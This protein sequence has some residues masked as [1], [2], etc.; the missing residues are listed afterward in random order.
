[1]RQLILKSRNYL[2]IF[3]LIAFSFFSCEDEFSQFPEVPVAFTINLA[4]NND[5]QFPGNSVYFAGVGY[6]GIIVTCYTEGVYY[7]FDAACP[8]EISPDCLL[9]TEGLIATCPCCGSKYTL[10]YSGSPIEGPTS[11]PLKEYNVKVINETTL[12]VYN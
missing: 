8:Y 4:Y 9:E 6:G 3:F 2:S 10:F 7:A 1:M 12:G 5:L 11:A